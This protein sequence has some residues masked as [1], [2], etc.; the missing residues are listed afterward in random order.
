MHGDERYGTIPRMALASAQ[1]FGDRAAIAE[2]E[3][4]YSFTEVADGMRNFGAALVARGLRPTEPVA[5]W[6]PNSAAWVVAALGI[7]AAGGVLVPINTRLTSEEAAYIIEKSGAVALVAADE[8]LGVHYLERL[9][10]DRPDLDVLS[11]SLEVPG[12]ASGGE[13]WRALLRSG[14]ADHPAQEE[15]ERRIGRGSREDVSDIIFTSGT[16]GFPKGV[17]LRHGSSLRA[18]EVFN[19]GARVGEG[20]VA[21]IALPFFHTFGYKA[22]WMLN[23]MQGATTVPIA[24]FDPDVVLESIQRERVTHMPGSP[25]MFIGMLD[26]PRCGDYDLSS[27]R[28][29]TVSASTVPVDLIHR[30]LRRAVARR[31]GW[32][33]PDRIPRD[34]VAD[35]PG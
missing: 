30:L 6:A 32:L 9:R 22:G 25:T 2:L 21:L 15:V 4:R 34:R 26:H 16:T 27:L 1:R 5:L 19:Q 23:L 13:S 31:D 11:N 20:D 18:Y 17:I 35:A 28:Q 12:P 29:V 8:F 24:V 33:R 3:H 14:E 7:L 10:T